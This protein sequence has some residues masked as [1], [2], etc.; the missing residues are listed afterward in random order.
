MESLVKCALFKCY[1]FD[2]THTIVELL[3][4]LAINGSNVQV[5]VVIKTD[6]IIR[7]QIEE[8]FQLCIELVEWKWYFI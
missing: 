7:N 8:D 1:V 3:D 5:I 4:K 6:A 2:N